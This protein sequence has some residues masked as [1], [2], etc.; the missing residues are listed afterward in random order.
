MLIPYPFSKGIFI[1]GK[2]IR[3]S[4]KCGIEEMEKKRS[5]LE[6]EL[7][8]LT[9]LADSHFQNNKVKEKND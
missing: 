1:Y 8:R 2:L 4:R 3:V 7:I 6:Q 5:E 9:H